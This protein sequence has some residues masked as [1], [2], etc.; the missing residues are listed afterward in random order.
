MP[1]SANACM[2]ALQ[3]RC[4][5]IAQAGLVARLGDA[6]ES[7][8]FHPHAAGRADAIVFGLDDVRV[9]EGQRALGGLGVRKRG[10]KCSQKQ[11][12]YRVGASHRRCVLLSGFA[13]LVSSA[14]GF[15]TQKEYS[16]PV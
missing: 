8:A 7:L 15:L 6:G 5:G 13:S 3:I 11:W 4:A 1:S 16:P 2:V 10:Q 14:G 9:V 12:P